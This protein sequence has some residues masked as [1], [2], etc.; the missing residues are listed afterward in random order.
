ML[1]DDK[2]KL[3]GKLL[4][5]GVLAACI[6]FIQ[7]ER[8]VYADNCDSG[9]SA[10]R[11]VCA[12]GDVSCFDGCQTTY[13]G[14]VQGTSGGGSG[15]PRPIGSDQPF[16]RAADIDYR[17]CMNGG[18]AGRE[19]FDD[20]IDSGLDRMSCCSEHVYAAHPECY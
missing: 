3:F 17:I 19:V 1:R 5:L 9:Y 15:P 20:C 12:P 16:C 7:D 14:C 4:V 6:F 10:C 11:A 18:W 2:R 8:T 13:V